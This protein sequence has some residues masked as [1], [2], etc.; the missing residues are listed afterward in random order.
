MGQSP[1]NH[2]RD[3]SGRVFCQIVERQLARPFFG[4]A[5]PAGNQSRQPS[6]GGAVGGQQ[7]HRRSVARSDFG[8]DEQF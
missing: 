2:T 6:I 5:P 3:Q 1:A 8:A 4:A 7:D